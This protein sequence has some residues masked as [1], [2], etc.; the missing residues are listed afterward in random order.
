MQKNTPRLH[1]YARLG[2]LKKRTLYKSYLSQK[3]TYKAKEYT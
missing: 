1:V 3:N 2:V